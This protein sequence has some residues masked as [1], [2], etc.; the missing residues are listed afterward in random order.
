LTT[1]ILDLIVFVDAHSKGLFVGASMEASIIATRSDI[2][3][4]F[5]GMDV[6]PSQLLSGAFQRPKAAEP[7][8]KALSEVLSDV[9][10]NRARANPRQYTNVTSSY[11]S[12]TKSGSQG[13][14]DKSYGDVPTQSSTSMLQHGRQGSHGTNGK[15]VEDRELTAMNGS[16]S[17][18]STPR[19]DDAI[20]DR[21][22][23][24]SQDNTANHNKN[25]S[26]QNIWAGIGEGNFGDS[27]L[28][29]DIEDD[30]NA[31]AGANYED[32]AI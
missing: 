11:E 27:E 32:I 30:D 20:S 7:L 13:A 15:H 3:R 16:S 2:N 4:A 5:Y 19:G 29:V 31:L 1:I 9:E 26:T 14:N 22:R 17:S 21:H 12:N 25:L 23:N 18:S 10:T 8:Y 24:R 6:K 28:D